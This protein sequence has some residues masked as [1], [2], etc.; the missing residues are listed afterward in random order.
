LLWCALLGAGCTHQYAV[1]APTT[2]ALSFHC[3]VDTCVVNN[4]AN[5]VAFRVTNNSGYDVWLHAW[6]LRPYELESKDLHDVLR[7]RLREE[8]APPIPEYLLVKKHSVL[9]YRY[10]SEFFADYRLEPGATYV[11][12][13]HYDGKMAKPKRDPIPTYVTEAAVLDTRF[14]MCN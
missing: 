13:C 12:H 9:R 6:S 8:K 3:S 7:I 2:L 1:T 4:Q 14:T 11:L 10:P 5:A